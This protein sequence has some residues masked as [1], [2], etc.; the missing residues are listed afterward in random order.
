MPCGKGWM[1]NWEIKEGTEV[2][3]MLWLLSLGI[4]GNR[5]GIITLVQLVNIMD[6]PLPPKKNLCLPHFH[7]FYKIFF[8]KPFF[9]RIRE[10]ASDIATTGRNGIF[11]SGEQ[12]KYTC[13]V[14][15]YYFENA[16]E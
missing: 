5:Q 1:I 7:N 12:R 9:P 6:R 15:H 2:V 10:K 16:Q 13:L 14:S 4:L 3:C 11:M 8:S